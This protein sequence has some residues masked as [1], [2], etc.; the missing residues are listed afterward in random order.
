MPPWPGSLR[1]WSLPVTDH[2][3]LVPTSHGFLG[4]IVTEPRSTATA[5]GLELVLIGTCYG[6]R[7]ALDLAADLA[8]EKPHLR[9]V[10]LV[11]P[12]LRTPPSTVA[13]AAQ[14]VFGPSVRAV[15]KVALRS[16]TTYTSIRDR[17][18]S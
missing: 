14:V 13:R 8:G 7:V 5:G 4:G 17:V 10:G 2:P 15:R 6:G 12:H 3:V 18:L 16:S 9:A 1:C 11:T